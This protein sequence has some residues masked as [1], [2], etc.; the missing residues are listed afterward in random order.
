VVSAGFSSSMISSTNRIAKRRFGFLA[1]L[2]N[3]ALQLIGLRRIGF[4]MV[5]DQKH[6]KIRAAEVMVVNSTLVGLGELPTRLNIHPGDGK[7]EVCVIK[8]RSIFG[9]LTV[10]WN[11]LVRGKNRQPEF[12]GF[13]AASEIFIKTKKPLIV[14]ADGEVVG[15]TP[16]EIRVIPHAVDLIV[17]AQK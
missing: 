17:S 7:I 9:M 1:Y 16:V 13:Q 14:Q 12:R 5:I 10:A 15:Q 11:I 2:W 6:R 4:H 3:L 8:P